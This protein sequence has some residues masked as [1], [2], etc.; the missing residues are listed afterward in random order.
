[1]SAIFPRSVLSRE[2]S[3]DMSDVGH[4]WPHYTWGFVHVAES[5]GHV[6]DVVCGTTLGVSRMHG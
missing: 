6:V 3:L 4:G 5:D 1:M 2:L